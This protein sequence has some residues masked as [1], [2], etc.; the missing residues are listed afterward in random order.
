[1]SETIRLLLADDHAVVRSGLRLLLEAQPD[2]AIIGEAENGEEAIRRTAELRP[3]VVLMDIEM[4]GMNG[5]EAARRI[6]AQSPGTSVLAL[7]M[8]EDDQYFFEMLRAG[9]S[10]YVPKRAAPDELASAIRAVS[11]GEVFIHPSLAG[12]L[13]QDYLQRR[14]VE[15]QEQPTGDLTPREQEVLTL[16]AQ[17]LSNNEIA[18]QLV[19]SAK[20]VD[21]HRENIMRKLN[22]HNRVDLVKYALRKGLIDLEE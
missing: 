6:K 19:I 8:Y 18:D 17:G 22:L 20:T 4:P 2:L 12:R 5:I 1:M 13:V 3:D 9:A 21:R 10:G 7:T 15:V 14:D 16:I 11:R